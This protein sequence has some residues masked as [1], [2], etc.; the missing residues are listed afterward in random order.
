M[1]NGTFIAI[2]FV[3]A[4]SVRGHAEGPAPMVTVGFVMRHYAGSRQDT[5]LHGRFRQEPQGNR[6]A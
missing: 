1:P 3:L 6:G 5:G 2:L 4:T